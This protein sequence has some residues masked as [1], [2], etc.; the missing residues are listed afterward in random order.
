MKLE[1]RAV[2]IFTFTLRLMYV[3]FISAVR[4]AADRSSVVAAIIVRMTFLNK[5]QAPDFTTATVSTSIATQ[6][7]LSVAVTIAS[8]P[9][10]KKTVDNMG[11]GLLGASLHGRK[12]NDSYHSQS[13][14]QLNKL[15][16]TRTH[17]QGAQEP[18]ETTVSTSQRPTSVKRRAS[19]QSD[20]MKIVR[21]ARWEVH[22]GSM[23]AGPGS[24]DS[25]MEN[26]Q[27]QLVA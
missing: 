5:L 10:L 9:A 17:F 16:A 6:V 13:P 23:D 4:T 8:I 1:K 20:E 14:H 18:C 2:A 27:S 24:E 15:S 7:V 21:V 12:F 22:S 25:D 19:E 11:T 3:N 26:R